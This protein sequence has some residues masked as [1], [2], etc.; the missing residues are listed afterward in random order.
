[1]RVGVATKTFLGVPK[2]SQPVLAFFNFV[3][4]PLFEDQSSNHCLVKSNIKFMGR[5]F[6]ERERDRNL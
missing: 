1:M 4:K 5:P 6:L 2:T 3:R